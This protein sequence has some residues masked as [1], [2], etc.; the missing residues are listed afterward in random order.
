MSQ[1]FSLSGLGPGPSVSV[2]T[3]VLRISSA[4]HVSRGDC[5]PA[6][7]MGCAKFA[8]NCTYT[9]T[10]TPDYFAPEMV[11]DAAVTVP[12]SSTCVHS[13]RLANVEHDDFMA[14]GMWARHQRRLVGSWGFDLRTLGWKGA[15]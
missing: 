15:L 13:D 2:H 4:I 12:G 14:A 8:T 1:V 7:D 10:G 6:E 11:K 3:V 5:K 9:V